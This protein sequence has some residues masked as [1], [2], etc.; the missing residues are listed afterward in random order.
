MRTLIAILTFF[1]ASYLIR[2][3]VYKYAVYIDALNPPFKECDELDSAGQL[4]RRANVVYFSN[5][6]FFNAVPVFT[7]FLPIGIILYYHK[8]NFTMK[9]VAHEQSRDVTRSEHGPDA[10][11]ENFC[12]PTDESNSFTNIS[13]SPSLPKADSANR[14]RSEGQQLTQ[15]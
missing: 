3:L 5:D 7:D 6:N 15:P 13:K 14:S 8:R 1:S 12:D 4:E 10:E 2:V 11:V 9:S